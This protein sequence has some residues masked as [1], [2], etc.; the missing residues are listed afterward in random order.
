[1]AEYSIYMGNPE[2]LLGCCAYYKKNGEYIPGTVIGYITP[3]YGLI[4][5]ELRL[6]S[7]L[8]VTKEIVY[9]RVNRGES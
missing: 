3:R 1:M 2:C 8:N 4:R 7:G 9:L 5:Y 6:F